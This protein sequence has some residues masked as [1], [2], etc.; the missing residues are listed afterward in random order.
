MAVIRSI[1]SLRR[2]A[3]SGVL[4]LGLGTA[5]TVARPHAAPSTGSSEGALLLP[6]A[7]VLRLSALGHRTSLADLYWL[8]LVQYV[9]NPHEARRGWPDLE[10]LA[11]L[12][13]TLDP[14]YGY[15]Y[16]S[17]GVLLAASDRFEASNRILEKGMVHIA[18]RWELPFLA[19]FNYWHE[20]GDP[21]AGGRFLLRASKLPHSP[22]YMG[23]LA[24]RLL[25]SAGTIEAGLEMLDASLEELSDPLIRGELEHRRDQLLAEQAL[26]RLE[27]I[28]AEWRGV[29]DRIPASLEELEDPAI[30]DI[31]SS[32][33]GSSIRFDPSTG[34]VHSSLLKE[35]LRV[36]QRP[37]VPEALAAP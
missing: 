20:L 23:E 26:Q 14:H 21:P 4:L 16:Q 7:E 31:L 10:T 18:D 37:K 3:L 28:I 11:E 34:A 36:Y 9:G 19:G 2:L 35:R 32:R 24:T 15:A 25:S 12:I 30:L 22:G 13:T 29:H 8:K 1:R 33:I 5:A 17:A 6:D 27:P